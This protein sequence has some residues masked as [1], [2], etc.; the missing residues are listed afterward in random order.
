MRLLKDEEK[1]WVSKKCV[2]LVL[3][4]YLIKRMWKRNASQEVAYVGSNDAYDL[5]KKTW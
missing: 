3:G 5:E 2:L 4:W 1:S